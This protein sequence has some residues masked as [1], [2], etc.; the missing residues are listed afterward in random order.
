MTNIPKNLKI[1]IIQSH[2]IHKNYKILE[3]KDRFFSEFSATDNIL[4][5]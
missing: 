3:N 2:E 1:K 5:E 4:I